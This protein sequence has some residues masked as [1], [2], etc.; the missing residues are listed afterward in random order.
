MAKYRHQWEKK[1]ALAKHAMSTRGHLPEPGSSR[2][3]EVRGFGSNPGRLRMF[4]YVPTAPERALVVVLHGCTQNAEIYDFGAGWSTLAERYG[5]VLLMPQQEPSNNPNRCFNWF[6]SRHIER[7]KGETYSI[8]Q[9]VEIMIRDGRRAARH[10]P[11]DVRRWRGDR[12]V[13]VPHRDQHERGLR[14]HVQCAPAPGAGMGRFRSRRFAASASWAVAAHLGLAR[15][16][17]SAGET[18]ERRPSLRPVGE[19]ARPR[20]DADADAD[21]RWLSAPGLA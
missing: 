4:K 8:R 13:A 16:C 18:G 20:R 7:D 6:L 17:R 10:L 14:E 15:R 1:L 19:R 3:T 2:L 11:G 5:F 21:G 9:M 12:G